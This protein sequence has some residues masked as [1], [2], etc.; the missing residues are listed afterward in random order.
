M[1]VIGS[2]TVQSLGGK[3]LTTATKNLTL[4]NINVSVS[5]QASGGIGTKD[6]G[7]Y[8][9]TLPAD[10]MNFACSNFSA[11][12]EYKVQALSSDA[13]NTITN[14]QYSADFTGH[15][16]STKLSSSNEM[17]SYSFKDGNKTRSGS[18]S[19][20]IK[21]SVDSTTGIITVAAYV[22][23]SVTGSG[24][25]QYTTVQDMTITIPITYQYWA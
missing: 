20:V 9:I 8:S 19:L 11:S 10:T 23:V 2:C 5:A 13:M 17:E 18:I 4:T 25:Y 16:W 1:G 22:H 21:S 6:S 12:G 15:I 24:S 14:K 3:K 7:E